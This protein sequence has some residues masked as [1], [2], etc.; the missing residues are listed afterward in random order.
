[1]YID[2]PICRYVPKDLSEKVYPCCDKCVHVYDIVKKLEADIQERDIK[3]TR[4]EDGLLLLLQQYPKELLEQ[5]TV[6]IKSQFL[7][8]MWD[9]IEIKYYKYNVKSYLSTKLSQGMILIQAMRLFRKTER[10]FKTKFKDLHKAC[11]DY[12]NFKQYT[13]IDTIHLTPEEAIDQ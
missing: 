5:E 11:M 1:M 8:D 9:A 12:C 2:C 7:L 10:D 13:G 4:M 3:I 6:E